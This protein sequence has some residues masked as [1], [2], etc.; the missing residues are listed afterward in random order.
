MTKKNI[1][2]YSTIIDLNHAVMINPCHQTNTI[3]FFLN[4]GARKV[5]YL[6]AYE[7]ELVMSA[8]EKY[9]KASK[10]L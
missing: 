4:G 3:E 7:V 10:I 6:E 2:I 5:F 1:K 8:V 9:T